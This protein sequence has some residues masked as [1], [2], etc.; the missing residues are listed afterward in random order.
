MLL[1]ETPEKF[2]FVELKEKCY[3]LIYK[4]FF[5]DFY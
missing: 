4:I 1:L 2:P 5:N 3:S